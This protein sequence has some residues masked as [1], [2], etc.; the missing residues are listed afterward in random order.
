MEDPIGLIQFQHPDRPRDFILVQY[1]SRE[2]INQRNGS[3]VNDEYL[4]IYDQLLFFL[5]KKYQIFFS[6]FELQQYT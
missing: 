5:G 1:F 3:S 2:T 4:L 6:L